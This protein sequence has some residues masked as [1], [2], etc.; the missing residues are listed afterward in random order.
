MVNVETVDIRQRARVLRGKSTTQHHK[1]IDWFTTESIELDGQSL[2][3]IVSPG[4]FAKGRLD[5]GTEFLLDVLSR[6]E[7]KRTHQIAD[8]ACGTG[9]IA[10]WFANRYP[11]AHIDATDAD[12][13]SIELT[14]LNAPTAHVVVSDGWQSI[15]LDRCYDLIISNPPVHLGK[16]QDYSV[17]AGLLRDAKPRLHYRG[18]IILVVQHHVPLERMARA[19]D[20]KVVEVIEHTSGYKVWRVGMRK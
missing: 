12:S 10:R 9:V 6:Y 20:Y 11:D 19:E 17:L 15:G 13:W 3:W 14:K 1:L 5:R 4:V 16:E 7:F 2:D 8:F 18:Q